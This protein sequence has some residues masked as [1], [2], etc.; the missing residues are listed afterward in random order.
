MSNSQNQ[1]QSNA[2]IAKTTPVALLERL[3]DEVN[4][5]HAILSVPD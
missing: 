5:Y 3:R 4:V 2:N 1:H